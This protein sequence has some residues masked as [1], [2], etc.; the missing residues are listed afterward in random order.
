MLDVAGSLV[1]FNTPVSHVERVSGCFLNTSLAVHLYIINNSDYYDYDSIVADSRVT[2][3]KSSANVGYGSANNIAMR[4][5]LGKSK[6]HVVLNPDIRFNG[7]TL[8]SMYSFMEESPTVAHLMPRI[9]FPNG[10]MQHLCKLLPSPFD[11]VARRFL[12]SGGLQKMLSRRFELQNLNYAAVNDVP[13][14][15]GCFMFFR[16]DALKRVGLFDE[17]FFMYPEDIDIT[18]RIHMMYRTVYFPGATVIHEHAK[19]SYRSLKMLFVHASNI[20]KYFNKWG[21]F[22][23]LERTRINRRISAQI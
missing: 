9:V 4:K 12:P 17:R 7:G 23:D 11:L 10:Q 5:S 21:W 20:V 13:Y 1:L 8:E 6:Y 14:L 3:L 2:Y 22:F 16:N 19:A 15:S 18:R